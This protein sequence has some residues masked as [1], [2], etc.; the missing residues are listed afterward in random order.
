[1]SIAEAM[2]GR[3]GKS[4]LPLRTKSRMTGYFVIQFKNGITKLFHL[5]NISAVSLQ[6][7]TLR[8]QYNFPCVVGDTFYG[9]VEPHPSYETIELDT[10]ES[11][12]SQFIQIQKE[13]DR[14]E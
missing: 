2:C 3:N 1:V 11:A 14:L 6:S 7:K 13:F 9:K 5:R 8:I 12:K 4:K 10:E